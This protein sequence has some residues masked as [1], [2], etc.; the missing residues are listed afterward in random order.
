MY[1]VAT[2]LYM[3]NRM[4]VRPTVCRAFGTPHEMLPLCR[5]APW[6]MLV[7][8]NSYVT[9]G[10]MASLITSLTIVYSTVYL[11]ADQRKQQSSASL[12]FVW[13]IHRWPVNFPH[14]WPVT[15]KMFPFDYVIMVWEYLQAGCCLSYTENLKMSQANVDHV[16]LG[17]P[18]LIHW[19]VAL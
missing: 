3:E 9:I 8:S 16:E 5:V 1:H 14:K 15:R 10:A 12:A 11:C 7:I 19:K 2:N 6:K 13:G 4:V 18:W 17:Y